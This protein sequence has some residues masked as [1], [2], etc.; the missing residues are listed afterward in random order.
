MLSNPKM[1]VYAASKWAVIGW[2]ES[3][4]LEQ[5]KLKS[6][7][8]VTTVT[9]SYIDTGM[10]S[11]VKMNALIPILK[12]ETAAKKIITGIEKNKIF[13]RMPA[14]VSLIPFLKGIVPVKVF[15]TVASWLGVYDSMNDFKG[16]TS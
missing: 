4:R 1:S 5:S 11:G 9:P 6:G 12:P 10:F 16:R 14:M 2:S 3:V 15:D 13:V 7:V 8:K